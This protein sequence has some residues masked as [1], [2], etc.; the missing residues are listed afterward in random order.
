MEPPSQG[1][2]H[3]CSFVIR[4]TINILMFEYILIL[5]G[6]TLFLVACVISQ[7]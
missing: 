5:I 7:I 2:P 3:N 6:L 4:V 1:T